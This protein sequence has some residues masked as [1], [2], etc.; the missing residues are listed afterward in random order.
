M[1]DQFDAADPVHGAGAHPR[2]TE[3]GGPAKQAENERFNLVISVV[4]QEQLVCAVRSGG[5]CEK[6]ESRRTGSGFQGFAPET[7]R[8]GSRLENQSMVAGYLPDEG[9][10]FVAVRTTKPVI[11]MAHHQVTETRLEEQVEQHARIHP[12]GNAYQVK[13]VCGQNGQAGT[14]K[15]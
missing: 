15:R 1:N 13:L 10:I 3:R 12:P 8:G 5:F 7:I 9:G 4:R 6:S 11:K 14:S 2:A